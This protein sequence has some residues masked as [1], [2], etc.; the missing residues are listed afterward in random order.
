MPIDMASDIHLSTILA[1]LLTWLLTCF[2]LVFWHDFDTYSGILL[3]CF[4][5][6]KNISLNQ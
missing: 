2:W 3:K 6:S 1:C 5:A 4:L